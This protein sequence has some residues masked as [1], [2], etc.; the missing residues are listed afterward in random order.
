MAKVPIAPEIAQVAIARRAATR[1]SLLRANSA[2]WPASFSP[3]VV[4]SAWMAWLRPTIAVCLC[5][6]ARRFSAASS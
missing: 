2:Q 3:N 4:G 6:T 1:R 5:S